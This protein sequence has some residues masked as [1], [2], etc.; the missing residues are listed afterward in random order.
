MLILL[1]LDILVASA[2]NQVSTLIPGIKR[3]SF[4]VVEPRLSRFLYEI[5]ANTVCF[6]GF[7]LFHQLILVV[8]AAI[9]EAGRNQLN[10]FVVFVQETRLI[11][12][13][14]RFAVIRLA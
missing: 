6:G 4:E 13:Y 11:Y 3:L 1:I 10:K 8:Y 14:V 9:G 12:V 2:T 7:G 5:C